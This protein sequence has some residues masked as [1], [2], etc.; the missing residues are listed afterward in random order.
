MD[1]VE[2]IKAK[3]SIEQV[4]GERVDLKRSGTALKGLCPFHSEKT[5][6]FFVFPSSGNYKCFGCG[7]GGDIFTFLQ[8]SEKLEFREVLQQ[9]AQRAG[10]ELPDERE[11]IKQ[12]EEH[13]RLFQANEAAVEFFRDQLKGPAGKPAQAYFY[14]RMISVPLQVTFGLGYAPDSRR[15]LRDA[16]NQRGFTDEELVAAG[17]LFAPDDGGQARDRFH[18]RVMI[19][20]RDVRGRVTGF[21]GRLIVDGEPKYMN[22]P[23]TEI[24][25]KSRSLFAIEQA[26]ES[27]KSGRRAVVVEGYLDAIRAH[28]AGFKDVVAS[29]GTAI[30]TQQ[31]QTCARLASTVV[32]ALDPDPAGQT[33]AVRA[34][35]AA[36]VALPRRQRQLPDSLGRRMVDVGLSV[37]LRIA[38]IPEIA[39]DPDEVIQ[40][41]PAEWE[42]IVESSVPVFEF[43]FD[44]VVSSIDRSDDA[45]RQ[46]VIDRVM[47]VIQEFSFAIGM[48][49]AWIERLAEVTGVQA[50][51]LQNRLNPDQPVAPAPGRRATRRPQAGKH[52]T[53]AMPAK[54]FDAEAEAEDSMLRI[55]LRH[56]APADLVLALREL[57]SRRTEVNEV[58]ERICTHAGSGRRPSTAELGPEASELVERL[59]AH[60]GEELRDNQVAPAVKLHIASLRLIGAKRRLE[61]L[62]GFLTQIGAEDADSGLRALHGLLEEK[63]VLEHQISDLQKLVVS[64]I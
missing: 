12:V 23:Q 39:G 29:L 17:L 59:L 33:A 51:L 9:L 41:D 50:R 11:R 30:T 8:T 35:L 1:A 3:L 36:L 58:V 45:W 43:F 56:P 52:P 32:L 31:L 49:A 64:G 37:D 27:I 40:R 6:S 46:G 28:E 10:V 55:L 42:R 19:P 62:Q 2:E 47:P 24:F 18:G 15:A 21:G 54:T 38:R 22:S 61:D 44:T 34:G 13:A 5:P 63:N 16:L 60:A 4:V 53:I 20:I 48:Q 57:S 26:Q 14:K 25:D 7:Q